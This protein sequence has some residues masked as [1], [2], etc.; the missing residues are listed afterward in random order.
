MRIASLSPAATEVLWLLG[1]SSKLVCCDQFSDY[2]HEAQAMPKLPGHQAVDLDRLRTYTPDLVL[3]GTVIQERLAAQLQSAGYQVFHR[4][5]RT[6][7]AVLEDIQALGTLLD[8]EA[9]AK[10]VVIGMQ[11]TFQAVSTRAKLL[12]KKPRVYIE[13]WPHPPMASGNWVPELVRIAGGVPFPLPPGA[14]SREVQLQE[15]EKFDPDLIVLSW[16]GA[17]LHADKNVL[18]QREGW[19]VLRACTPATVRVIDDSL[20]NRP[21][22]RLAQGAERLFGWFFEVAHG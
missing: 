19:S 10:R 21:G 17:G 13:E 8:C 2:P 1:K 6:L 5:P 20:L 4:D 7:P 12:P 18:L 16:C 9:S 11:T 15:V 3:T 14:L 22:P